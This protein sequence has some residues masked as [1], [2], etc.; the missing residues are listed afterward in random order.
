MTKDI[1]IHHPRVIH[2]DGTV[3]HCVLSYVIYQRCATHPEL[4]PYKTLLKKRLHPR[5][6]LSLDNKI[7][8][9]MDQQDPSGKITELWD[10]SDVSV[11]T[12]GY[13]LLFTQ[14]PRLLPTR[15]QMRNFTHPAGGARWGSSGQRKAE[16]AARLAFR[17]TSLIRYGY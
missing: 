9:L 2:Q 15:E 10:K 6:L 11:A 16:L 12:E 3:H 7:R 1:T 17:R 14:W 4:S 8:M 5:E 13:F